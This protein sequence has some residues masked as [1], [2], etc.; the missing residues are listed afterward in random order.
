MY[1]AAEKVDEYEKRKNADERKRRAL[2]IVSDG[3]DRDSYYK[4]QQL[5]QLLRESDV[6]IFAVG[7]INEL[8][9]ESGFIKKSDQEKAKNLLTRLAQETGGKAYFPNNLSEL[10]GIARDI[11]SE[12]R[13]Q[14]LIAYSPTNERQDG[15]FRSIK[16]VVADGPN[17]E[18]RI[19]VT[20]SGR[21]TTPAN[22]GSVPVL[23][24][25]KP[26]NN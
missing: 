4:E 20:R 11:A 14:Y 24:S 22:K 3:E 25:T 23:Q 26:K 16:V 6:Q 12:L 8:S 15:T 2:I 19:A 10:P 9:K 18:K 1:L 7:F 5:F 17:K 21:T 13:T